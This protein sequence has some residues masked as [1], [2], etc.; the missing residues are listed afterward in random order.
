MT[1]RNKIYFIIFAILEFTAVL[2]FLGFVAAHAAEASDH[3]REQKMAT[4]V[5][6]HEMRL[7]SVDPWVIEG[8][9]MGAVAA[10]VYDD[11]S[12]ER[13]ADYWEFYDSEDNLLAVSWF[14]VIVNPDSPNRIEHANYS[15]RYG[16]WR[17]PDF[18]TPRRLWVELWRAHAKR[19]SHHCDQ[20]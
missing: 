19:R 20:G 5:D 8:N 3:A 16:A 9:V 15:S 18:G 2:L 12:T 10:Y 4:G 13:P 7:V 17:K 6:Q 11:V 14:D 1:F